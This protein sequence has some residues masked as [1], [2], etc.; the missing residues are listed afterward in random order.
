MIKTFL[1]PTLIA[2][3]L[4]AALTGCATINLADQAIKQAV[5][6]TVSV[7][8]ISVSIDNGVAT[9]FGWV[10][11]QTMADTAKR[12]ALSFDQVNS[13]IDLISIN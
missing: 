10:E 1:K 12:T 3:S 7:G 6:S 11:T 8:N 4:I 9:I 5:R 13:V 2:F